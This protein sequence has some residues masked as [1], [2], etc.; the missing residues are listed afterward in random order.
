M[1]VDGNC[2]G[3]RDADHLLVEH[4]LVGAA[5]L[6]R[7][8]DLLGRHL[9]LRRDRRWLRHAP[10]GLGLRGSCLRGVRDLVSFNQLLQRRDELGGIDGGRRCGCGRLRSRRGGKPRHHF[11]DARAIGR[12]R[13]HVLAKILERLRYASQVQIR[14]RDVVEQIAVRL[15]GIRLL[16]LRDPALQL[17]SRDEGHP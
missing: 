3:R 7:R 6:E 10:V 8:S 15:D 16:Q 14:A 9:R 11:H 13:R 12:V 5:C 4:P 2:S 17:S 1:T